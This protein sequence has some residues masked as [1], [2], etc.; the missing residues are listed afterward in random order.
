MSPSAP[1]LAATPREV[2]A[3]LGFTVGLG[4]SE[5]L[6]FTVGLGDSEG[7]GD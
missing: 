7:L 6:G 3:G 2:G 5:G 4:D 1:V